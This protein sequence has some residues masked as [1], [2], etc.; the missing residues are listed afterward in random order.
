MFKNK[1]LRIRSLILIKDLIY[2][3]AYFHKK[4]NSKP[5]KDLLIYHL[6]SPKENFFENNFISNWIIWRYI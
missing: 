2:N 6:I 3:K 4:K 1:I 5:I